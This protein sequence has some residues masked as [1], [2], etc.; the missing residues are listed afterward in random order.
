MHKLKKK[1]KGESMAKV[2][3]KRI[4]VFSLAKLQAILMAFVG[5]IIG[6][7]STVLEA[8]LG[9]FL[10]FPGFGMGLGFLSIVILPVIY[11]IFGFVSGAI[12]AFLYNL[13][14]KWVGGIELEFEE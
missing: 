11:A 6:I 10:G 7:F 1:L 4:G 9:M 5:L 13:I 12:G 8:M 3:L 14:A 2:Q